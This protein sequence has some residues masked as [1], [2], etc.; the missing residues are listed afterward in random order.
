MHIIDPVLSEIAWKRDI[1]SALSHELKMCV[2]LRIC[3]GIL[4]MQYNRIQSE[5]TLVLRRER[6]KSLFMIVVAILNRSNKYQ[7]RTKKQH[8]LRNI[9]QKIYA[10]Q[11]KARNKT[12]N[13]PNQQ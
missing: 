5:N 10:V 3:S 6:K 13:E 12:K 1:Q 8:T 2:P 11:K 7:L 9:S 4:A